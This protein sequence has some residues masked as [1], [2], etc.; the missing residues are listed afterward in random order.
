M[1]FCRS[2]L[3]GI[4]VVAALGI[5]IDAFV[6]KDLDDVEMAFCRSRLEGIAVDAALGIDIGAFVEKDLDA[7][8][9]A[10]E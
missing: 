5:D 8:P 6:E 3:E 1:A 4:A 2:R 10:T 9:K 7:V